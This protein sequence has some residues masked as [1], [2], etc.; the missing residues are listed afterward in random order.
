MAPPLES[1][2]T[3]L[4]ALVAPPCPYARTPAS[5]PANNNTPASNLYLLHIVHP[6]GDQTSGLRYRENSYPSKYFCGSHLYPRDTERKPADIPILKLA[7]QPQPVN[8]AFY[9]CFRCFKSRSVTS[10]VA[11]PF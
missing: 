10:K 8:N 7:T 1:S 2:T 3:P 6:P 9:E 11:A 4:M 5:I